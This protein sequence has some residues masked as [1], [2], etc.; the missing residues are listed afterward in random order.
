TRFCLDR[1]IDAAAR[2]D[3]RDRLIG[4]L[5]GFGATHGINR[6]TGV[7]DM[8]WFQQILTF[9]WRCRPLGLPRTIDGQM[10]V[11]LAIEID[12]DTPRLL[13]EAGIRTGQ[14]IAEGASRAA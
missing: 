2:R 6:Y 7:A 10:L 9:G 4:A 8:G 11:A 3:A 5:A 14:P 12:E 13:A 1:H